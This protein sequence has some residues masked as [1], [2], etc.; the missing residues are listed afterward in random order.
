MSENTHDL[1][2]RRGARPDA[3]PRPHGRPWHRQMGAVIASLAALGVGI[4]AG[5]G[6]MAALRPAAA[7]APATPVAI[8]AVPSWGT[9][10]IKGRVAEI[11]GNKFVLADDSGRA[12]VETGPAGE[13]GGLVARDEA[14]TVQGRAEDGFIHAGFVV[15]ADGKVEALGPPGP[16]HAPAWLRHLADGR[17]VSPAGR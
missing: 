9:V 4:A 15:H 6:G 8:S 11:Y 7:M 2:P 14:V 5:A 12:L 17:G 3:E 10:T 16:L 13:G 1:G